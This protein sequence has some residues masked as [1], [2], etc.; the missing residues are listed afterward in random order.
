VFDPAARFQRLKKDFNLP[1]NAIATDDSLHILVRVDGQRGDEHPTNGI[2]T[3]G[4]IDFFAKYHIYC[5]EF[6]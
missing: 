6:R 4:R 5:D 2:F 1:S 3:L